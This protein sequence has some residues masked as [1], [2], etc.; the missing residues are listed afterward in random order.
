VRGR[1]PG[2]VGIIVPG[3]E[4]RFFTEM[5]YSKTESWDQSGSSYSKT[6]PS[7]FCRH[8]RTIEHRSDLPLRAEKRLMIDRA[9]AIA[10]NAVNGLGDHAGAW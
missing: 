10:G 3:N 7:E 2:F 8:G 6:W 9:N 4:W 1:S 5:D